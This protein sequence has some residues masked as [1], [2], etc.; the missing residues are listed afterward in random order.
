MRGVGAWL[1]VRGCLLCMLVGGCAGVLAAVNTFTWAFASGT[2][3][4]VIWAVGLMIAAWVSWHAF[5]L[6]LV[7]WLG[8]ERDV[9]QA[10]GHGRR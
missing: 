8:D 5:Y 2:L 6:P 10:Q 4:G 9:L 3:R 7:L 1:L